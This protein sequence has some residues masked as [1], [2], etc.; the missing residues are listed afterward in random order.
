MSGSVPS[1]KRNIETPKGE[2]IGRE[3]ESE[4]SGGI[5]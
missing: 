2:R 4:S 5:K 3:R 1:G